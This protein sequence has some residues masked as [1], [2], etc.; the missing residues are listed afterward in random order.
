[1]KAKEK[2]AIHDPDEVGE[3][4]TKIRLIPSQSSQSFLNL[5]SRNNIRMAKIQVV[6]AMSA[7][8]QM[9]MK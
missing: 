8:I 7:A 2:V 4:K 5:A 1:M 9:E 3:K 6:S